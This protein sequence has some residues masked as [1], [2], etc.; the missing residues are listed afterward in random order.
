[1]ADEISPKFSLKGWAL[2]AWIVKNK[3]YIK[4][5]GS[6]LGGIAAYYMN[7]VPQPWNILIAALVAIVGKIALDTLDFW[8]S[9]VQLKK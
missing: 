9:E 1:M 2:K 7:I 6:A 5:L 8:S 3:D 4:T